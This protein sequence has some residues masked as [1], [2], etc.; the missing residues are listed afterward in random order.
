M[1]QTK[2]TGFVNVSPFDVFNYVGRITLDP[3]TDI[4]RDSILR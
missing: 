4:W 1:E 3:A 2:A